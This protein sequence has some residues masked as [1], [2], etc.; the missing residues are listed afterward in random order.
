M[1]WTYDLGGNVIEGIGDDGY[2]EVFSYEC[3]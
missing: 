3:W 2:R 1:Q